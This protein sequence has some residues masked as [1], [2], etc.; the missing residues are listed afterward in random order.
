MSHGNSIFAFLFD[1][2]FELPEHSIAFEG[3]KEGL[4]HFEFELEQSFFEEVSN[5]EL[6]GGAVHVNLALDRR[7]SML[8]ADLELNGSIDTMCD[9]CNAPVSLP[10]KGELRQVYKL[11]NA[12][13]YDDDDVIAVS[14]NTHE[15]NLSSAMYECLLLSVPAR[16]VHSDGDCDQEIIS[17]LNAGVEENPDN[18]NDPRW[19]VLREIA[20]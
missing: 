7:T 20:G 8:V 1:K 18:D 16:K 3:L 19:N 9:R 12:E 14:T 10:V 17:L 6:N 13:V 5:E 2:M 11:A 15:I 4:H